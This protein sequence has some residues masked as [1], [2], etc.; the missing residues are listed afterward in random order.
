MTTRE[1]WMVYPLL[2]LTLGITL[3]DKVLPPSPRFMRPGVNALN[4]RCVHLECQELIRCVRLECQDL[5]VTDPNGETRVRVG[6]TPNQAGQIEIYGSDQKMVMVAGADNTGRSGRLQTLAADTTPQ[7]SLHSTD[8]GGQV[9]TFDRDDASQVVLGYDSMGPG[10]FLITPD[11][12]GTTRYVCRWW[13]VGA[14]TGSDQPADTEEP[15][16][17]PADK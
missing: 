12:E 10:T 16:P 14:G 11:A 1:R 5:S 7:V 15:Q 17:Q 2:F 3:R 6:I 13:P 4:V 8:R 9:A